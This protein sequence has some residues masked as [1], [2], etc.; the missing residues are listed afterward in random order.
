MKIVNDGKC[1]HIK[2]QEG[3]ETDLATME[4]I[5]EL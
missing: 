4:W 5:E 1:M 3:F 2:E